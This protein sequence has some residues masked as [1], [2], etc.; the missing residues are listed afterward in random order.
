MKRQL[1]KITRD[2]GLWKKGQK[3]WG[4]MCT[5]ALAYWVIGRYKGKGRWIKGWIHLA[6]EDMDGKAF[7]GGT[8]DAKFVE[9][10]HITKEF[11]NYLEM[12]ISSTSRRNRR[13]LLSGVKPELIER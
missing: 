7:S 11:D 2:T 9:D 4:V 5:G 1:Y 8:P 13:V 3:V 10:V 12:L 6:D